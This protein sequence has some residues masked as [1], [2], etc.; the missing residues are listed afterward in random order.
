M[1]FRFS[2]ESILRLRD[3]QE[4]LERT[5]LLSLNAEVAR[6]KLEIEALEA[7]VQEARKRL[8]ENLAGGLSGAEIQFELVCER[9]R[10]EHARELEAKF[11]EAKRKVAKQQVVYR[12]ARQK[13]RILENLR[14]RRKDVY[15]R[16]QSR[17]EQQ[18]LDEAFSLRA[19]LNPPE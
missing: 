11:Q 3:G 2:L 19:V 5:R 10:A 9:L 18:A 1:P 14:E 13:R 6:L 7:E 17:R 4:R 8:R 15:A 12:L 16:E